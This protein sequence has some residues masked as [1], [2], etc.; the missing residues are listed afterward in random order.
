MGQFLLQDSFLFSISAKV[1]D[2]RLGKLD[3]LVD[4]HGHRVRVDVAE[5]EQLMVRRLRLQRRL[6][7]GAGERGVWRRMQRRD[8]RVGLL[9]QHGAETI[10]QGDA[11]AAVAACWRVV[12]AVNVPEMFRSVA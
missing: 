8:G 3:D 2:D 5:R 1:W 7:D 6:N 10:G 9:R 11:A 4:G 12:D